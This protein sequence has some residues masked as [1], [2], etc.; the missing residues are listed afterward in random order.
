MMILSQYKTNINISQIQLNKMNLNDLEM[1]I[2]NS[3]FKSSSMGLPKSFNSNINNISSNN[4]KNTN[5]SNINYNNNNIY[6]RP[7]IN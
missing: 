7:F 5:I 6:Q 1:P 4:F 2:I 3:D